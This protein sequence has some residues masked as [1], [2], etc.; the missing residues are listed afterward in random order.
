MP[1]ES[2]NSPQSSS[3]DN[4][5][6][7]IGKKFVI[8]SAHGKGSLTE[9]SENFGQTQ[10]TTIFT[11]GESGMVEGSKVKKVEFHN[12][13]T[14]DRT[15]ETTYEN[16]GRVVTRYN[17]RVEVKMPDGSVKIYRAKSP[18]VNIES[19]TVSAQTETAE[20]AETAETSDN[21]TIR[22]D[23]EPSIDKETNT[24]EKPEHLNKAI[25]DLKNFTEASKSEEYDPSEPFKPFSDEELNKILIGKY[26]RELSP[27]EY[28]KI[29]NRIEQVLARLENLS[30]DSEEMSELLSEI[31]SQIHKLYEEGVILVHKLDI[32]D[33]K[34]IKLP[35][36]KS[37]SENILKLIQENTERTKQLDEQRE[38][39]YQNLIKNRAEMSE[40]R[41]LGIDTIKKESVKREF[42]NKVRSEALNSIPAYNNE[43]EFSKLYPD[44]P[45]LGRITSDLA[46]QLISREFDDQ[47]DTEISQLNPS[48]PSFSASR[49]FGP[50]SIDYIRSKMKSNET[51]ALNM[52]KNNPEAR[53]LFDNDQLIDREY[54]ATRD[55]LYNR[56][57]NDGYT[58]QRETESAYLATDSFKDKD[59][60]GLLFSVVRILD[61]E[62]KYNGIYFNVN[63]WNK[64]S[65]E[66]RNI[67]SSFYGSED[68][69]FISNFAT[70]EK[71]PEQKIKFDSII[72]NFKEKLRNNL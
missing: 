21:F 59:E 62:A 56:I 67:L 22:P 66:Q 48:L 23:S 36:Q 45:E 70:S 33:S 55:A 20:T 3:E 61:S 29:I 17:D 34:F 44:N 16:S 4:K 71:T 47:L 51:Y 60:K 41:S 2:F 25:E 26:R 58:S 65:E 43:E 8:S 31:R 52:L 42:M 54:S 13:K 37:E 14:E 53:A 49:L 32:L 18:E 46:R 24:T 10:K 15:R 6:K 5:I 64:V 39:L 72:A 30:R 12:N 9:G 35:A 40:I 1:I 63:L 38:L 57:L 11:G 69:E 28:G 50:E 27:E 68:L 19:T 7:R